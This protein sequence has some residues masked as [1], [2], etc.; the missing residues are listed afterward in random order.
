MEFLE[1]CGAASKAEGGGG[2]KPRVVTERDARDQMDFDL[3]R[4]VFG[5]VLDEGQPNGTS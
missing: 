3:D 5:R 2:S 1:V 4:F